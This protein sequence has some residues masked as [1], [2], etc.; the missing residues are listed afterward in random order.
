MASSGLEAKLWLSSFLFFLGLF[1]FFIAAVTV[2]LL[3]SFDFCETKDNEEKLGLLLT[4]MFDFGMQ[5]KA[6]WVEFREME[7]II[8]GFCSR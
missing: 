7:T 4:L 6:N 2:K 5:L 3:L 1:P 8:D